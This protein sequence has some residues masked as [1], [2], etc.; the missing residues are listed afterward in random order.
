MRQG[1]SILV[2][3]DEQTAAMASPGLRQSR[4]I[5]HMTLCYLINTLLSVLPSSQI[6]SPLVQ[7]LYTGHFRFEDS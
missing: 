2:R 6:F 1:N 4:E 5:S 7:L 3:R